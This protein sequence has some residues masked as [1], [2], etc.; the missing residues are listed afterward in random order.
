MLR[1]L[2]PLL[3]LQSAVDAQRPH[4]TELEFRDVVDLGVELYSDN[5][6]NMTNYRT[7]R[8]YATL[9]N[10]D[11]SGNYK[12]ISIFAMYGG[13]DGVPLHVPPAYKTP[14]PFDVDVGG[15]PEQYWGLCPLGVCQYDSWLSLSREPFKN[16]IPTGSGLNSGMDFDSWSET[17]PLACH[18]G[19]CTMQWQNPA[20]APS[21]QSKT[22][23]K[24]LLAQLTL[25]KSATAAQMRFNLRGS[26]AAIVDGKISHVG[27]KV[28]TTA[29]KQYGLSVA[30]GPQTPAP[31]PTGGGA[32]GPAAPSGDTKWLYV[33]IAVA[34][35]GFVVFALFMVRRSR[36]Q[37]EWNALLQASLLNRDHLDSSATNAAL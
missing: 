11:P 31:E 32:L 17:V 19:A 9:K 1:R 30:V 15:V 27:G 26:A 25:K 36:L 35:G 3:L 21:S 18:T 2:A 5:V 28:N 16:G 8:V 20:Q 22:Q 33:A 4:A 24:L 14:A 12:P 34:L 37:R 23:P 10:R 7:Y 6:P 29:W 13:G